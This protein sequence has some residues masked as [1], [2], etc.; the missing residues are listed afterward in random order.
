M[1]TCTSEPKKPGRVSCHGWRSARSQNARIIIAR[2][3]DLGALGEGDRR[4]DLG[5][6]RVGHLRAALVVDVGEPANR[7]DA[8]G[9]LAAA[10]R[11]GVERG[12][13]GADGRVDVG[14]SGGG[15]L[16]DGFLGVR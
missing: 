3:A 16:G 10:P 4:T 7:R 15:D 5:G 1:R 14:R 2:Q 13:R 11:S 6:D 8:L 9:G 12:A